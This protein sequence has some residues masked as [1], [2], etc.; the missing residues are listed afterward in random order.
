MKNFVTQ[1]AGNLQISPTHSRAAVILYSSDAT[2]EINFRDH[3][4]F[5]SFK[6]AVDTLPHQR[7]ITRIDIALK[8]AYID[9]FGPGGSAR[10]GVQRIVVVLTDGRQTSAGDATTLEKASEPLKQEGVHIIAV[11]VGRDVDKG[12]LRAMV[13]K[14]GDR[15]LATSFNELLNMVGSLVQ[16]AC[17]GKKLSIVIIIHTG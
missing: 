9:L 13:K 7:G 1:F 14:D 10:R 12:E 16:N 17:E 11:G 5:Q 2:T 4:S 6:A 3:N 8:K 15:I